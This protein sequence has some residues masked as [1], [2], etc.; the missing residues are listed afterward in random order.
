MAQI[1]SFQPADITH[2]TNTKWMTY[3]NEVNIF[4]INIKAQ[5]RAIDPNAQTPA[6]PA[7]YDTQHT[8]ATA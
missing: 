1:P 7:A 6:L 4:F 5:I 8:A 2:P 3:N